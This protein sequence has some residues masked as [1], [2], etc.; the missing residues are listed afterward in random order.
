MVYPRG[1]WPTTE[2]AAPIRGSLIIPNVPWCLAGATSTIV[3]PTLAPCTAPY[4][5]PAIA[6]AWQLWVAAEEEVVVMLPPGCAPAGASKQQVAIR[7][8]RLAKGVEAEEPDLE[9]DPYQSRCEGDAT[10]R[11]WPTAMP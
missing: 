10:I 1:G 8:E 9:A 7:P 5:T 4:T 11:P 6:A 2:V 3:G